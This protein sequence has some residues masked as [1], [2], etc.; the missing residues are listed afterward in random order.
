MGSFVFLIA[1]TNPT[2][3]ENEGFLFYY[4]LYEPTWLQ[5]NYVIGSFL[6]VYYYSWLAVA[7]LNQEFDKYWYKFINGS[8]MWAYI[9]HYMWIVMICQ[10][11][12][13]P[14]KLSMGIA[15]LVN[16]VCSQALIMGSYYLLQ[17]LG[18]KDRRERPRAR[19]GEVVDNTEV[20]GIVQHEPINTSTNDEI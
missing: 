11:F 15:S 12:V 6:W 14:L 4:P 10:I 1:F 17:K 16:L 8:S 7:C 5:D 13:R 2:V 20:Q 18:K 19:S 3:T 9:S